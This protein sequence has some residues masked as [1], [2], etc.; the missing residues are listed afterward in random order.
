MLNPFRLALL[1]AAWLQVSCG[2]G[3]GGSGGEPTAAPYQLSFSPGTLIASQAQGSSQVLTLTATIDRTVAQP[4][5]VAILDTVGV[6]E[7]TVQIAGLTSTSYQVNLTTR[8]SMSV[9]VHSG[10]LQV[11]LCL[12]NPVTC[13]S[14][15]PGSPFSLPYSFT[16]NAVTAGPLA[17]V[18][19]AGITVDAYAD[20]V[21]TLQLTATLSPSSGLVYPRFVDPNGVFQPNP[22]TN[23]SGNVVTSTL[24]LSDSLLT[25]TH[26]G[27]LEL[28]VCTDL[29]CTQQVAGSPV[30]VPY[31]VAL[32]ASTN[33]TPLSRA[34]GVGEWAQHQANAAH[35]GHVPVTLDPSKFNRRWRWDVPGG[36][37]VQ[38]VVTS[39]GAVYAVASGYFQPATIYA[40][41]EH[42]KSPRWTRDFGSIF[43]ANPP[44]THAGAL[45]L[46]T[47]GHSDTYMWGFDAATGVLNFRTAFSS[48]WE[49]YL[50]PAIANGAVYTNGGSYGGLL[51]F[52]AASGTQNWFATLSQYDQ[53]TP[54]VDSSHAYAFM[55]TGLEVINA[56][57]GASAFTITDPN[58]TVQAY[59][60]FGAPMI[61]G[62]NSVVVI[63]GQGNF[64][65][66][67][68]LLNFDIAARGI[69][70]SIPGSFRHAPAF[71]NGVIYTVNGAQL[72]ARSGVDGSR[73]WSWFPNEASVDPFGVNY[74][75]SGRNLIA[76][77]NLVFLSTNSRTYALSLATHEAVWTFPVP[78]RLALSP[79]NVLYITTEANGGQPA[80]IYAI[81]LQ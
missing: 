63:N 17:Q 66:V 35:A 50:A 49:H 52:D 67:N 41:S 2:G 16:V 54:A 23:I 45:Y 28:R 31:S 59:S 43:A 60:V 40:L 48:Q 69:K 32:K 20:E 18:A 73:L 72:E 51:S 15:L 14:P 68:R 76:T 5:N 3:G 11:R 53:W 7:P 36:L 9:G 56:V 70:W 33:L 58:N 30:L 55:P 24:F 44:S 29:P 22:P 4:V 81:N 8:S 34:A 39:A 62:T 71:A 25:G 57:T 27:N 26:T 10:A 77:D 21:P 46:A 75:A 42:D 80:R 12:D 6:I 74:G 78:G 61:I 64:G 79:N 13:A 38:P 37:Q 65:S 1:A 47:S 19:P